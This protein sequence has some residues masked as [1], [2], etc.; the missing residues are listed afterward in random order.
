M[1]ETE[2]IHSGEKELEGQ[3]NNVLHISGD[4]PET[5]ERLSWLRFPSTQS[6]LGSR[7]LKGR[8]VLIL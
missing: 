3:S 5:E 8:E 1:K 4:Y 6:L 7:R 2:F